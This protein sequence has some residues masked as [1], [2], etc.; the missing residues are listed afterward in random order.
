MFERQASVELIES[1]T[2]AKYDR[3][4]GLKMQY[5]AEH[6]STRIKHSIELTKFVRQLYSCILCAVR[7]TAQ[8]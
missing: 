5:R 1:T 3:I 4:C 2:K 8:F 7:A 6:L